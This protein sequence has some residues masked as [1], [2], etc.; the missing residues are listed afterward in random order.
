VPN[1]TF[2]WARARSGYAAHID[3]PRATSRVNGL[4]D[5]LIRSVTRPKLCP[6]LP[7]RMRLMV[8]KR[9]DRAKGGIAD[10]RVPRELEPC[11]ESTY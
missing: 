11:R 3:E 4:T 2:A 9:V 8:V 6:S 7:S 5:M 1:R 10:H